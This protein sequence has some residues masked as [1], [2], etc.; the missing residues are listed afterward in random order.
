M[1]SNQSSVT[2]LVMN[3][4]I[5]TAGGAAV[6]GVETSV[7]A[8]VVMV[9]DVDADADVEMYP[10]VA[11]DGTR[12]RREPRLALGPATPTPASLGSSASLLGRHGGLSFQ[13]RRKLGWREM[14]GTTIPRIMCIIRE[15]C[16]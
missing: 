16:G 15:S 3:V 6:V 8:A 1:G 2:D 4:R 11:A 10:C 5:A 14:A 12:S 13:V 9:K 7:A